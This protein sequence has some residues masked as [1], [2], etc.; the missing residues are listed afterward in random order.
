MI[1]TIGLSDDCQQV[2]NHLHDSPMG[3][4]DEE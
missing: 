2:D 4:G 3:E 1:S